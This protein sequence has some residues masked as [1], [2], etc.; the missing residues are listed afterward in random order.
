MSILQKLVLASGSPRRI[1]LLQQA[2]IEPDRIL[3][4]DI[5]ETPLRAEHPRSLAKR[6]SKEK[7]E[8]A[9][10][11]LNTET[12]HAPSFVLAADTVVAVGRRILPKAET[13]DDAA[14]CLGLLS[15]RSHRVYSGIC[16]ITPGGKLRQ[17][18]VET[19]VRFKRLPREEIEAYVA[20]GEWRGKAGGYAVQGLAGSF[21]VKLVGSY[22]NIVGLP[23]YE[24][25][26]LLS[27]EGFKI[28]QSWLTARP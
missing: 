15:G 8:K 27:G 3:P 4:A 11:S 24:T 20:S 5:D 28:H 23:L 16:L 12:D 9:F 26:A 13:L 17:R 19:R 10:A 14:N 6:L 25:V 21:V 2:G 18:L 1:E 7:A 22:T